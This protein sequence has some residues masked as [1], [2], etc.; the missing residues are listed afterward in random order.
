METST[1]TEWRYWRCGLDTPAESFGIYRTIVETWRGR[2]PDGE[3]LPRRSAFDFP[4]F[5]AWWGR[6]AIARIERAPFDVRFTLWGTTLRDWWGVDYTGR[7]IG[8]AA[9]NP[10][11]W[12]LTEGLYFAEM[13]QEPF[14]GVA[15]GNLSQHDRSYISVISLDLPVGNENGVSHVFALHLAVRDGQGPMQIMPDCPMQ[16][17]RQGV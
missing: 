7:R 16:P 12:T 15:A 1:S 2:I 17:I 14:I 4:D 5:R 9:K 8:E 11:A 10:E 13:T 3:Q 6:V